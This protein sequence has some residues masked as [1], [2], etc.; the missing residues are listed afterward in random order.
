MELQYNME[1]NTNSRKSKLEPAIKNFGKDANGDPNNVFS[2]FVCYYLQCLDFKLSL[3]AKHGESGLDNGRIL[4]CGR[5]LCVL[6]SD[7]LAEFP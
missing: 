3:G 7:F 1:H 4:V 6:A 5:A 2:Y